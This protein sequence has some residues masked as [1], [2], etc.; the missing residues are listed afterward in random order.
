MGFRM[1]SVLGPF[2]VPFHK[3]SLG[4]G[5]RIEKEHQNQFWT[6]ANE[7]FLMKKQGC[8][9]FALQAGR[10]STPWYVGKAGKSFQQECFTSDKLNKYNRALFAGRKGS[11]VL[12]FVTLSGKKKK[13]G[14]STIR[15]VE[16]YLIKVA[17]ETNPNLLNKSKTRRPAW[18][19]KGVCRGGMG[20]PTGR[21]RAF[22]K[23]LGL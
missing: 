16:T 10:G 17:M 7:P 8:Y 1:L 20:K 15:D 2:K 6:K 9:V 13:I 22:R 19:I 11:P 3:H 14:T 12:F 5:K 23:M 18:G 21:E 4:F